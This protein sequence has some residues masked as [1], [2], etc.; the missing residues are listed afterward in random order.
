[1][2][3]FARRFPEAGQAVKTEL[4]SSRDSNIGT[5]DTREFCTKHDLG[6]FCMKALIAIALVVSSAPLIAAISEDGASPAPKERLICRR[7]AGAPS[8][9]SRLG[10][11]RVCR[12]AAQ[13]RH[14]SDSSVDEDMSNLSPVNQDVASPT[15]GYTAAASRS[16]APVSAP[17]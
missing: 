10:A 3:A 12:T 14:M 4:G 6:G 17:Q 8:S 1:L 13:W 11:Q 2:S 9:D 5:H 7:R 15:E 16:G